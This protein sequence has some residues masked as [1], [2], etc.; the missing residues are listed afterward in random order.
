MKANH[1]TIG[2]G[3]INISLFTNL[4]NNKMKANH[5]IDLG[6]ELY[7]PTVYKLIK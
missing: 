6:K 4:S 3:N 1:N 2:S 5:N 7:T